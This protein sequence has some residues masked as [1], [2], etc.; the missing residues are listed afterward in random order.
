[1]T[2]SWYVT[3]EGQKRS[4][5]AKRKA[6]ATQTFE[7]EGETKHFA[8]RNSTKDRWSTTALLFLICQDERFHRATSPV[9]SETSTK[10]SDLNDARG[11]DRQ[12]SNGSESG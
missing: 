1:M 4:L 8:P 2:Y 10:H 5:R 9:G 6:Q 11:P 12:D 7:I 3:F